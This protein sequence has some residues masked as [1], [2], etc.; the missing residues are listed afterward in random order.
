MTLSMSWSN[1]ELMGVP[2][3]SGAARGVRRPGGWWIAARRYLVASLAC[4]V[5]SLVYEFFSH[6]VVSLWMVALFSYPLLLGMIPAVICACAHVR[7]SHLARQLWACGVITLAMGSCLRGVLEIY[8]TTSELILP[9]PAAGVGL[10]ALALVAQVVC[11]VR[12]R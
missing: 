1:S 10:L 3:A 7:E 8:G 9:Y 12:G 5:F 2:V 11:E 6:G 4:A